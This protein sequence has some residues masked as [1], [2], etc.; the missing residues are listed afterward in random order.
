M[1]CLCFS[2]ARSKL[3]TIS[4]LFCSM[5]DSR[6]L[7]LGTMML[8]G[9]I[10]SEP[11]AK[12]KRVSPV[13]RLLVVRYANRHPGSSSGYFLFLL[14]RDFLRQSRIVLLD[15]SACPLL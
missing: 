7:M 8:G 4:L 11:N 13:T 9:M 12:E 14:V 5:L 2:S 15:A 3:V 6:V 10:A 1:V